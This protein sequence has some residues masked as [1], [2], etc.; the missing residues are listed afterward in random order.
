MD[1][2]LSLSLSLSPP[3]MCRVWLCSKHVSFPRSSIQTWRLSHLLLLQEMQVC[4]ANTSVVGMSRPLV[5]LPKTLVTKPKEHSL[6]S[7]YGSK[8]QHFMLCYHSCLHLHSESIFSDCTL[9]KTA[10]FPAYY[11]YNKTQHV[12]TECMP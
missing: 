12:A 7:V 6:V 4:K 9:T 3:S 5:L 10:S 2:S 8:G 11:M 1:A